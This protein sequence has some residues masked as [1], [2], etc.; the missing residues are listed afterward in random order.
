MAGPHRLNQVS[1]LNDERLSAWLGHW[2]CHWP[3]QDDALSDAKVLFGAHAL[4]ICLP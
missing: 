1:L 2:P 3:S 4:F